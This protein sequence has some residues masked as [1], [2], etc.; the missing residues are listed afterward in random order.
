MMKKTASHRRAARLAGAL[1]LAGLVATGASAQTSLN[2]SQ[3]LQGLTQAT[4]DEP[5]ITAQILRQMAQEAVAKDLPMTTDKSTIAQ[6]LDN[7]AQITVQIQ[8]ALNSAIIRPESYATIGS[9]AD[10]LHHPILRGYRFLVVGNTDTTG[11]RKHNLELSQQRAD[12]IME[13]LVNLYRVDA[14]RLEAA[15][16]GQEALETPDQPT[17]PV[18]RRVQVFN[19]GME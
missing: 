17:N 15:G 6:K 7:L 16:L 1:A 18:N 9:I 14:A 10:A 11:T 8:F 2:N 4:S 13:A 19:I 3:I 12:A 5:T